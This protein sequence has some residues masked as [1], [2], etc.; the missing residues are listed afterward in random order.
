MI[1]RRLLALGLAC[2][3]LPAAAGAAEKKRQ[4]ETFIPFPTLSASLVRADGSRGVLSVEAGLDVPD[5]ALNKVALGLQPR[6]R[7]AYTR[8]M[9][10]YA[11]SIP[12]AGAPNPDVLGAQLQR[13]TDTVLGRPGA[14]ILFGSIIIN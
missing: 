12:P 2:A 1:R 14:K 8:V 10:V 11:G 7:D 6:L 9:G 5:P 4:S 3:L 13:A